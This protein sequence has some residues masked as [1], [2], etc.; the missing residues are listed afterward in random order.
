MAVYCKVQVAVLTTLT[1]CSQKVT[2]KPAFFKKLLL[3]T[4]VVAVAVE[5]SYSFFKKD[6]ALEGIG[7]IIR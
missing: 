5:V 4:V 3:K 2:A 6:P 7:R 1:K